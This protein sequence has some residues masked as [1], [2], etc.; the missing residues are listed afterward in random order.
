MQHA[1]EHSRG[2]VLK[3]PT[4]SLR[5]WPRAPV[6][7]SGSS[8]RFKEG[9]MLE[10]NK[11]TAIEVKLDVLMTRMNNQEMRSHL[12][13]AVGIEKGGEQKCM[14]DEGLAHEG[15]YQVKEARF[16]GGNI[17]Y[18]FK[19]N[20][21]LPTHYTPTLRNIRI[22]PMEVECSKVL[23]QDKTIN[24]GMLHKVSKGSSSKA[25]KEL[26]TKVKEGPSLLKIKY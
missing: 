2:R 8:S 15:P 14:T 3:K 19:P 18:N 4:S 20:N 23:D 21:N 1:V 16:V 9:D 24:S 22:F 5:I 13:N 11:M 7:T 6:E 17:S 26:R 10:L 12:E 25:A